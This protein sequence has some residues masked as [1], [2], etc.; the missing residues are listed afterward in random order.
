VLNRFIYRPRPIPDKHNGSR[1]I[2]LVP[3][4]VKLTNRAV[5]GAKNRIKILASKVFG[6]LSTGLANAGGVGGRGWSMN[7]ARPDAL[8]THD[9]K[10]AQA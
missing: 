5:F 10:I 6:R 9:S 7:G 3:Q 1:L 8:K 4:Y 2:P